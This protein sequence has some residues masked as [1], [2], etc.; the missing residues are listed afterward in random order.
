MKLFSIIVMLCGI[1]IE[2]T[3]LFLASIFI[4]L[5]GEWCDVRDMWTESIRNR[6]DDLI[7]I[8]NS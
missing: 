5:T 2:V 7:Q 4:L 6:K 8:F 3:F 1:L